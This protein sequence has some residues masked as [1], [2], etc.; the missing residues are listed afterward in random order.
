MWKIEYM[1]HFEISTAVS[2][3]DYTSEVGAILMREG[4]ECGG[5]TKTN[6]QTGLHKKFS[7]RQSQNIHHRYQ[8]KIN[9]IAKLDD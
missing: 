1:Y 7:K 9:I 6:F 5:K 2:R 8:E 4:L 3:R